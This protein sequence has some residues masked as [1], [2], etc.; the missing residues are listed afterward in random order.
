MSDGVEV[1]PLLPGV[2]RHPTTD[3]GLKVG[4]A[5]SGQRGDAI[6][7][8]V[9]GSRAPRGCTSLE[10]IRVDEDVEAVWR[11]GVFPSQEWARYSKIWVFPEPGPPMI[12]RCSLGSS[13]MALV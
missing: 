3:M 13:S 5:P 8:Q 11:D 6:G 4:L 10:D 1:R 7:R 9:Q 12:A 2:P